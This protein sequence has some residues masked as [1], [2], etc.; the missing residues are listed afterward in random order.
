M[1]MERIEEYLESG[2][3]NSDIVEKLVKESPYRLVN[4]KGSEKYE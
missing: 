2:M 1:M 3:L 4:R